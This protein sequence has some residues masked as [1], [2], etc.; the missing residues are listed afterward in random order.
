MLQVL[1][2]QACLRL[3]AFFYTSPFVLK[4]SQVLACSWFGLLALLLKTGRAASVIL[5]AIMT[6]YHQFL[7]YRDEAEEHLFWFIFLLCDCLLSMSWLISWDFI[8]CFSLSWFFLLCFFFLLAQNKTN[9]PELGGF[10]F[11]WKKKDTELHKIVFSYII[12]LVSAFH[13]CYAGAVC[14]KIRVVYKVQ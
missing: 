3:K 1:L 14:Y 12:F 8:L 5:Q 13:L 11:I 6:K 4:V 9:K 7:P 2:C 10:D